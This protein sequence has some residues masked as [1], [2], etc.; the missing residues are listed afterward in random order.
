M[1]VF[2]TPP[3]TIKPPVAKRT[4]LSFRVRLW[5]TWGVML[6][7]FTAM[8]M[9]FDLQFAIVAAS[10]RTWWGCTSRPRAFCKARR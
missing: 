5:L 10:G 3:T 7:L 9:S 1:S 4:R 8:F 6:G 2:P